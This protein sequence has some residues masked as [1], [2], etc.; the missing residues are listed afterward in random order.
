MKL[1]WW[2]DGEQVTLQINDDRG[3]GG[4]V[5]LD[6]AETEQ[7]LHGIAKCRAA[8]RDPVPPDLDPGARLEALVDPRWRIDGVRLPEGRV[9]MLRHPGFGWLSFVIPD[10]EAK[11]MAEWLTKELPVKTGLI[12][13]RRTASPE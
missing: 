13:R 6:G 11:A 7:V 4:H 1:K 2:Q 10:H 5:F 3:L 8:L 9:L 12:G